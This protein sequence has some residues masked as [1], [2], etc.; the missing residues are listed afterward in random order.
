VN[1][2]E[3]LALKYINPAAIEDKNV[4]FIAIPFVILL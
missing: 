1:C 3:A 4:F 2:A